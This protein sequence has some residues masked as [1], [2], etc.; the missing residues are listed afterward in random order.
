MVSKKKCPV[1]NIPIWMILKILGGFGVETA[2]PINPAGVSLK[3]RSH[4]ICHELGAYRAYTHCPPHPDW[5][6]YDIL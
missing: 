1:A 2:L 5:I 3:T 6:Y 4:Q